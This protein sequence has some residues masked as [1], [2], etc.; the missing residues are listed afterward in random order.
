MR[1][2]VAVLRG[3]TFATGFQW[4]IGAVFF[5]LALLRFRRSVTLTQI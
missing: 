2:F 1:R 3:L 5:F 4:R